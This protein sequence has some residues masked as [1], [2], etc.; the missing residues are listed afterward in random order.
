VAQQAI[1]YIDQPSSISLKSYLSRVFSHKEIYNQAIRTLEVEELV[2][3]EKSESDLIDRCLR[4]LE[5]STVVLKVENAYWAYVTLL[6]QENMIVKSIIKTEH[7]PSFPGPGA[8]Q[9]RIKSPKKEQVAANYA[10]SD[11]GHLR[12][13]DGD[14]RSFAS[15]QNKPK[16]SALDLSYA[17][18]LRMA[19]SGRMD[20]AVADAIRQELAVIESSGPGDL[21]DPNNRLLEVRVNLAVALMQLG[22]KAAVY[23]LLYDESEAILV[24]VLKLVPS[25]SGAK[26]NLERLRKNRQLRQV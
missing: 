26:E 25:H 16:Q 24:S 9:T 5:I 11:A 10:Y 20:N 19:Q 17:E 23:G 21:S 3:E 7:A 22:N 14:I 4:D 2:C 18:A 8:R 1:T 6:M 15:Q 12:R 13:G